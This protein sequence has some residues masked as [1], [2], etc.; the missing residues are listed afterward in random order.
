MQITKDTRVKTRNGLEAVLLADDVPGVKPL[1]GYICY[2][3]GQVV[4]ASWDRNGLFDPA[5]GECCND[6][7]PIRPERV[8]WINEYKAF[9]SIH[10][11]QGDS[12]ENA[13]SMAKNHEIHRLALHR[14]T[15]SEDTIYRGDDE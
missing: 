3:A 8:V 7:I 4:A 2:S 12:D 1:I 6:L 9:T 13:A 10:D 11:T 5:Q 14:I 15:L